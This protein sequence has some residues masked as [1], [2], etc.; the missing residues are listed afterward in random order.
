VA[1]I[2]ELPIELP[3]ELPDEEDTAL[4]SVRLGEIAQVVD[5]AEDERLRIRFDD[6]P[7]IKLSVQKQPQ[8]NTVEV[9]EAVDRQIARLEADGLIPEDI[10]V[11]KVD[12]QAHYVRRSLNNALMAAGSGA[13]L[14]MIVV[15]LF[16]GSLRRTLVIGSAIP[17]AILVTCILMALGGL[18]LNIM[19]LGGLALGVG[20]LVDNTIVML[21]NICPAEHNPD[22]AIPGAAGAPQRRRA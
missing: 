17:I 10:R 11:H 9:V 19:T 14:A 3:M 20:L 5:G 6:S 22:A 8:A 21:E 15:Y 4:R 7:G 1:E 13:A 16:L 12:D 2:I 18:T